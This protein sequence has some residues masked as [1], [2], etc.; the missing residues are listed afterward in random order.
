MEVVFTIYRIVSAITLIY[1]AY[2]VIMGGL[3]L[4]LE[5][6]NRKELKK[7]KKENKFAILVAARNEEAV[8]GNLIDSLKAQNYNKKKC[9]I[10]VV[11]NNT[12][13]NTKKVVK[14]HGAIAIDC[15][16]PVK[17]KADALS[18]AFNYLK[19]D[20]SIDA[21]VVFDADN[22]V[23][24]DFLMHM[25]DVLN[26]G[27]RVATSFRD[28]KN[29]SD[30]W[31]S[32]SYT[33]F[34]YIQNLF[35]CRSRM[36]LDG[37][38]TITGTGFMIK[39]EIIDDEGFNTYT[40]TED[41][42]F[43]G[44]CALKNEKIFYAEKAITYDEYPV[45]FKLSWKQRKRWSVGNLQCFKIYGWN[46]FKGFFKNR[47]VPMLDMAFNFSGVLAHVA[48]Y[49]N[50]AMFRIANFTAGNPLIEQD[51]YSWIFGYAIQVFLP[52]ITI[53]W[54][55]KNLKPLWKG[56]LLF[57]VFILSWVP[58]NI[59]CLFKKNIEWEEIKH[60]RAIKLEEIN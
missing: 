1:G 34:Y 40:L 29:P 37:N 20:K 10:Y 12:T 45:K 22:V 39:K 32:A 19:E 18:F 30:S 60:N 27:Y 3:G 4:I 57:P 15:T 53:L 23:H 47:K 48:V 38:A 35:F 24:P 54:L 52:I 9:D 33:I 17:T 46:L 26:N 50:L 14:D 31:I 36:G 42:E 44:Q 5:R 56:I 59:I 7:I 13:D 11:I 6:I 58:I 2:Y 51:Y 21:Y 49:L 55:K 16:V 43:T 25:N 8:I 28:A 41:M